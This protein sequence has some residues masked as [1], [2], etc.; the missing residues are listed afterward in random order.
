[1]EPLHTDVAPEVAVMVGMA[2]TVTVT[3]CVF[4]QPVAVLVPVTEYVVDTVLLNTTLAPVV[5][6]SPVDGVQL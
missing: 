1:M 4:T 6:L 5:V 3:D 2:F